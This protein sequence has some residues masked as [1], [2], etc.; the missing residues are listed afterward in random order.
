MMAIYSLI[1]YKTPWCMT[2]FVQ[3]TA[4]LAGVG[5]ST[6]LQ[7]HRARL[8]KAGVLLLLLAGMSH[9][10]WQAHRA[11]FPLA[12]QNNNPYVY[13]HTTD[14]IQRLVDDLEQLAAVA[15]DGHDLSVKLIWDS[16]YYWPLPWYLRQFSRVEYWNRVP[17]AATAAV[18]L[19]A[20]RHDRALS[21]QLNDSHFMTGYYEIRPNVLA[22]LWVRDDVWV[23]HVQQL[24][25]SRQKGIKDADSS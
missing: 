5:A 22:M 16:N 20:P 1:P 25:R 18:V 11:S 23:A 6:L 2:G 19:A 7:A 4:L 14:R 24:Q 9:L 3:V 8:W 21:A 17:T 12:A 10:G 13:A 15:P